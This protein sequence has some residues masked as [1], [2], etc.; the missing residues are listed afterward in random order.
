MKKIDYAKQTIL[1]KMNT[2]W[3][4]CFMNKLARTKIG[5]G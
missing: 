2:E 3:S 1:M 5:E 4:V